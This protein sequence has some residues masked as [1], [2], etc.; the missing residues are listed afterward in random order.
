M[1]GRPRKLYLEE[2]TPV[3]T[4]VSIKKGVKDMVPDEMNLS[5]I[6]EKVITGLFSDESET[7]IEEQKKIVKKLE[8]ELAREKLILNEMK[9]ENKENKKIRDIYKAELVKH[10]KNRVL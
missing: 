4:T 7:A 3:R 10:E 8:I 2:D 1:R 5:K 9:V 6:V